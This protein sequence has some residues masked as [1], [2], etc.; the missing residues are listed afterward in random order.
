[1]LWGT[2]CNTYDYA[3]EWTAKWDRMDN[4]IMDE[5]QVPEET[6]ELIFHKNLE[7]FFGISGETYVAK[8]PSCDG[9]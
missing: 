4:Q 2:D 7:R 3:S 5:L 1:M 6:R 8:A 9:R